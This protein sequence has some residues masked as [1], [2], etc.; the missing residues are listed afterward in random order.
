MSVSLPLAALHD[1]EGSTVPEGLPMVVDAHVHLF[2]DPLFQAIWTWFD[3]FGWPI[4]YKLSA[5]EV[6]EFLV[7]RGVR[8]VVG[9]HY[10]H[11]PGIAGKLNSHMAQLCQ[12]YPQLT[13]TATVFPGEPD[14]PRI[15]ADA[16]EIGLRGVKLHAHVQC[17]DMES[18]AMHEV[19][20]VCADFDKPLVVHFGREPK[21]PFFPYP[22]DPYE[23]CRADKLE[24]VLAA[25]PALKVCV[26]HMGADE[27]ED[28]CRL[29][30]RYDNLWLDTT[31]VY[32]DYLP[33]P[34]PPRL[35]D[36][37]PDRVLFGTDF[38]HI[39]YAW[40]RELK[41]IAG[42]SLPHDTLSGLLG[43]NALNLFGLG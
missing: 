16:F 15:L 30:E 27:Y 12:T 38:P 28:Y 4:R 14:T 31:M 41:R 18:V 10:A 1:E 32:A 5:T 9:L 33:G 34:E 23:V 37:R 36:I 19:F 2:P 29:L 40:D 26:P 3:H 11:K 43:G 24:K 20:R 42:M 39:P 25:Y 7:S 35:A 8:R 21:N 22:K 6:V 17:F 13:G